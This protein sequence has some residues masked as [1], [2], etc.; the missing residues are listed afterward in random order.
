MVKKTKSILDVR[1]PPMRSFHCIILLSLIAVVFGPRAVAET[2]LDRYVRE[3]DPAYYYELVKTET[4]GD[5]M[6]YIIKLTSGVAIVPDVL[7]FAGKRSQG[8]PKRAIND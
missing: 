3:P 4:S 1:L 7:P 6:T 5:G 8:I 2:A